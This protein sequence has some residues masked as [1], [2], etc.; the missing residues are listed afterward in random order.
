[1]SKLIENI[2]KILEEEYNELLKC[3]ELLITF[4]ELENQER[5]IKIQEIQNN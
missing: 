5:S 4:I 1:L 3:C 2:W